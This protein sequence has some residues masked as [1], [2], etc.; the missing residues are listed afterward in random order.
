[1]K[2]QIAR[3]IAVL[4][5]V[6]FFTQTTWATCGGG[7]GGGGG[8]MSG[9]GGSAPEVYYVPWKVFKVAE[10]PKQGLVLYWFPANN[11]EIKKSSLRESRTL[12]L[13]ASQCVAMK[14]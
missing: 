12:S 13:Y 4:L 3:S 6:L 1:M 5:L 10:A 7:G 9:G 8:G 11:D 14:L 2:T